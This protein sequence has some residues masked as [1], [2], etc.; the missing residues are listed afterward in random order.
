MTMELLPLQ[1]GQNVV[2]KQR[3]S[4]LSRESA[5]FT[6]PRLKQ[7]LEFHSVSGIEDLTYSDVRPIFVLN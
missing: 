5:S 1:Q 7:A 3:R 6:T 4:R 2:F